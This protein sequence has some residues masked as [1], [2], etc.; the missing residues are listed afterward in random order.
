MYTIMDELPNFDLPATRSDKSDDVGEV[1]GHYTMDMGNGD[2][3]MQLKNEFPNLLP[4][5]DKAQMD[6]SSDQQQQQQQQQHQ[7]RGDIC[8]PCKVCGDKS[9]GF[10]YGVMACEGCKGFFRR[11]IQKKIDYKCHFN[12]NCPIE[13]VNRNRCQHCRFKKCLAVGMSK[14][15]VRIGR[16]SK[17]VRQSNMDEI[18]RLTS[19]PETPEEREAREKKDMEMYSLSQTVLQA[20]EVNCQYSPNKVAQLLEFKQQVMSQLE[21]NEHPCSYNACM[22]RLS[23]EDRLNPLVCSWKSFAD[24]V[25]PSVQRV[26]EFAKCLPGFLTLNQDDQMSLIKQGFFE[27]WLI[28]SSKVILPEEKILVLTEG[29]IFD[30]QMMQGMNTPELWRHIFEFTTGFQHLGL[31]DM[32]VALFSAVTIISGDRGGLKDAH[33]VE[34]LQEKFLECLRREISRREERDNHLFAKL[35]MKMPLLRSISTVQQENTLCFRM[36][37]SK[38]NLP[39]LL[40]ELNDLTNICETDIPLGPAYLRKRPLDISEHLPIVKFVK[41]GSLFQPPKQVACTRTQVIKIGVGETTT[42][43]PVSQ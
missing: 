30:E 11:S 39:P 27:V 7:Q 4:E 17:R 21:P 5:D 26:V 24:S 23:E 2:D 31:S 28:Q 43:M 37:N 1:F 41:D 15:S 18:K 12:S 3:D 10:H 29:C 22:Q 19:R 14:E 34:V 13:R 16:Y 9:S 33:S 40:V 8:L 25:M 38:V 20:H 32:E 42:A 6:G 36:E 35:L